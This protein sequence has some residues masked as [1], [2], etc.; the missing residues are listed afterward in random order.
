MAY[1]EDILVH[2][3][4]KDAVNLKPALDDIMAAKVAERMDDAFLDVASSV[5]GN[6]DGNTDGDP[7]N[8]PLDDD[9]DLDTEDNSYD[10]G[11]QDANE[12][13]TDDQE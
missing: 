9:S 7:D 3:W 13:E 8:E 6:T 5:Y 10:E 12:F 1:I 11:T 2:A 4:N